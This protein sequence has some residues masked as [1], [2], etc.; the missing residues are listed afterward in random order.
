MK[1][2]TWLDCSKKFFQ[3]VYCMYNFSCIVF[4]SC[5][6]NYILTFDKC[7]VCHEVMATD[8]RRVVVSDTCN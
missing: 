3:E 1:L 4:L 5:H 6:Q 2:K 8:D 7:A